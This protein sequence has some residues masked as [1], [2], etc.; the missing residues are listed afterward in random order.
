MRPDRAERRRRYAVA[1]SDHNQ[2]ALAYEL[3]LAQ[4]RL[5]RPRSAL[6]LGANQGQFADRLVRTLGVEEMTCVELEGRNVA[7]GRRRFPRLHWVECDVRTYEPTRRYEVVTHLNWY[8]VLGGAER[9]ACLE[10]IR[11]WLEPEGHLLVCFGD[12]NFERWHGLGFEAV[13]AEVTGVLRPVS[14]VRGYEYLPLP[15][16]PAG[17]HS[18][19]EQW[20]TSILARR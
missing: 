15:G 17:V 19:S 13:V 8:F 9:R 2:S 11:D 12:V 4:L 6:D 7:A 3:C 18:M 14:I 1:C 10:R 20:Y 16:L 5:L